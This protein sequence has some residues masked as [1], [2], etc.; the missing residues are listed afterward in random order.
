[1]R[2]LFELFRRL[3]ALRFR[4]YYSG[5]GHGPALTDEEINNL[6]ER[7]KYWTKELNRKA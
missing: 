3:M 2:K 7:F 4:V 5:K 1:M 6:K